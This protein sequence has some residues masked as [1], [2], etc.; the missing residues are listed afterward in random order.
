L[1]LLPLLAGEARKLSWKNR[2]L[3]AALCVGPAAVSLAPL[4]VLAPGEMGRE[5][6]G[7]R[8]VPGNSGVSALP[9]L[10]GAAPFANF[11]HILTMVLLAILVI[12]TLL[13]W[14]KRIARDSDIVLL[15]ALILMSI[16]EFGPGYGVQYWLWV[17][18]VLLICFRH[19]S[20]VWRS[21]TLIAAI[22]IVLTNLALFAFDSNYGAF[23]KWS[24]DPTGW[25]M[26]FSQWMDRDPNLARLSIPMSIATLGL[27]VVGWWKLLVRRD[28]VNP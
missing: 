2:V 7:Y 15:A 14:F 19:G 20:A 23:L 18:P 22:I 11:S 25:L 1:A 16:F 5:V 28:K 21:M 4:Y 26:R 24:A 6:F 3:G 13:L 12:I 8:S 27:I 9:Q 10:L 17:A